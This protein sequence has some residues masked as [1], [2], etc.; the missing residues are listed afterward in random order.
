MKAIIE[1]IKR[2][3]TPLDSEKGE[4]NITRIFHKDDCKSLDAIINLL[5]SGEKYEKMWGEI[6]TGVIWHSTKVENSIKNTIDKIEQKYF[7]EER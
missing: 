7:P 1:L 6:K 5:E 3:I 2:R 4:V